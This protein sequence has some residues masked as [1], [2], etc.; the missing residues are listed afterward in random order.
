M[1]RSDTILLVATDSPR[2]LRQMEARYRERIV[3]YTALRS[4]KNAFADKS[5]ADNYKKGQD[6]LVDALLLSC[7]NFL[8]KP[9]SALSEFS[10]YFNPDLHNHTIELQYEVGVLPPTS[11]ITLHLDSERDKLRGFD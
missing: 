3:A 5:I 11:T 8:I 4:E 7:S 2:F 10:V 9:A 1:K 6:A